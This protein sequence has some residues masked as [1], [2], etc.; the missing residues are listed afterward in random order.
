MRPSR[1][2]VESCGRTPIVLLGRNPEDP[3]VETRRPEEWDVRALR[4]SIFVPFGV[5]HVKKHQ[6][7]IFVDI[8][9]P[10]C[11][12]R[13]RKVRGKLATPQIGAVETLAP[14]HTTAELIAVFRW[15]SRDIRTNSHVRP[16]HIGN[17]E[18]YQCIA[19]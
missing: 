2:V 9:W 3:S 13:H 6:S 1:A 19:L 4:L 17:F 18:K 15:V 12:V 16:D 5:A 7:Q 14:L 8:N 11:S 10:L